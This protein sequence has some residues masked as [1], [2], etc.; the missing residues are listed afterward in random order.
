MEPYHNIK[1]DKEYGL[2]LSVVNRISNITV[3]AQ[4][5]TRLDHFTKKARSGR[6]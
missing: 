1:Y 3:K 2:H 4:K 5:K 6:E